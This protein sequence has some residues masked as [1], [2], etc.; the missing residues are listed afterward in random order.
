MHNSPM[1]KSCGTVMRILPIIFLLSAAPVQ[2]QDGPLFSLEVLFNGVHAEGGGWVLTV[3]METEEDLEEAELR[4]LTSEGFRVNSGISHWRG[5][6]DA[7]NE[8]VLE[9][10]LTLTD[11][12]PQA[13]TVEAKAR[14]PD[15][16]I[17]QQTARRT[18]PEIPALP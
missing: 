1:V 3:T 15:G 12:L 9:L 6:L 10:A 4:L 17:F 13:V 11:V 18:T 14:T 2:A 8:V 5:R 7:G 16:R